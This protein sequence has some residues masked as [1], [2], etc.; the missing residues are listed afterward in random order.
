MRKSI[1][2]IIEVFKQ[3]GGNASK[4]ATKLGIDRRTVSYWVRQGRTYRGYI[5]WKGLKRQSTKPKTVHKVLNFQQE[6]KVVKLKQETGWDIRKLAVEIKKRD[7]IS[8]SPSTIYRT[9]KAKK[10]SLLRKTA[11]LEDQGFKM[12]KQ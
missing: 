4:A 5:K 1:R 2:E 12:E 3:C 9:I 7:K 6:D 11:N 8:V 10:P